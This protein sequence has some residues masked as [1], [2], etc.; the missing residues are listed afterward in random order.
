MLRE[1]LSLSKCQSFV[2]NKVI[3]PESYEWLYVPF[4][5]TLQHGIAATCVDEISKLGL[6][7][8]CKVIVISCNELPWTYE[9][10]SSSPKFNCGHWYRPLFFIRRVSLIFVFGLLS[11]S[12]CIGITET[13]ISHIFYGQQRVSFE[14]YTTRP[15]GSTTGHNWSVLVLYCQLQGSN[16]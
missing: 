11:S 3:E 4:V 8:I 6:V 14:T 12:V 13:H 5:H 7:Y 2:A 15:F 9:I 10:Q 1:V 16:L